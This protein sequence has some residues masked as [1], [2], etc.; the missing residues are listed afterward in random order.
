MKSLSQEQVKQSIETKLPSFSIIFETENLSSIEL[1]NI[2]RSLASIAAQDISPEQANEFLIIDGGYAPQEVID[3]ISSKYP[4]ITLQKAPGLGY[5]EAKMLGAT[6]TTGE[7]IVYCDSDCVY[8]SNW[9]RNILTPFMQ[10][11]EINVVAG[12]TST[13]VRN[14]Y[15]LAIA[16]HYFF[17]RFSYQE[18]PYISDYYFLNAVAF[19]RDFLLQY[20]IPTNLPLYRGNCD[21]HCYSLHCLQEN[22]IWKHPKAQATHEPPTLSFCIWRYLLMGRDRVLKEHIKYLLTK[23][24]ELVDYAQL[25]TDLNWTLAQKIKGMLSTI[26]RIKPFDNQ[27]IHAVLQEDKSRSGLLPL[28]VPIVIG[29]ELIFAIGSIVTYLKSDLLLKVY[30]Q[31]EENFTYLNQS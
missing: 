4:W 19:R 1:D 30:Y 18:E 14:A 16:M 2:Y 25:S 12:E 28:A 31:S 27:K 20:P 9:L 8:V 15:E 7:I 23:N 11:G 17:P 21:I 13:P 22:K 29:L 6:L 3:E 5:Y 26:K 10:S 24:S